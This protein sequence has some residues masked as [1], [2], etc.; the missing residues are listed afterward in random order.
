M[1][2]SSLAP[3]SLPFALFLLAL[4]AV[5]ATYAV[6]F[7]PTASDNWVTWDRATDHVVSAPRDLGAAYPR[8]HQLSNGEILLAYHQGEPIGNFGSG[9]TLR[10]SRDNGATWYRTTQID[11]PNERGFWGFCNPDFIELGHGRLLLVSAAR[12][13]AEPFTR[14]TLLSES[15]HGGLRLRFSND[16]GNTWGP[17][18]LIAAGRGRLWEPSVVQLPDGELQI[19]YANES[20][21][22]PEGS[23][24]CIES[25]LSTDGGNTWTPP[26]LVS[27]QRDCRNGMPATLALS[28]GHV[29]CAQEV[30]G[31]ANS[32]WIVDT[33]QGRVLS[34]RLAQDDYDFGAA[35]FLTRAL[36]G[37]TLLTFHSQVRQTPLFKQLNGAW[38]FSDIYVQRGDANG[39]HFGPAARPWGDLPDHTGAFFP[40]LLVLRDNTLVALTS[41]ITVNADHTTTTN[42]RWIKG[43]LATT[44]RAP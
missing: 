19:F 41:F 29:L 25:I 14:D 15:R 2:A 16:Y 17:P 21:D 22:Q 26:H 24:Q 5:P 1:N 44:R 20:P 39:E 30:V 6:P 10:K 42:I 43:R 9:I 38:L 12:A 8:A 28:N 33:L 4:L 40:S 34:H 36:D 23:S 7:A 18:R 3:L 11:G 32:P 27:A 35:P 31:L 37:D 13:R